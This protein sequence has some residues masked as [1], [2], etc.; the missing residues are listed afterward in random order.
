M[1]DHAVSAVLEPLSGHEGRTLVIQNLPSNSTVSDLIQIARRELGASYQSLTLSCD[2]VTLAPHEWLSDILA[3]TGHNHITY[4]LRN[5]PSL[6]I[7]L[8]E[9]ITL[10]V[11]QQEFELRDGS[12]ALS[13]KVHNLLKRIDESRKPLFGLLE[14]LESAGQSARSASSRAY[15]AALELNRSGVLA[16]VIAFSM[17]ELVRIEGIAPLWMQVLMWTYFIGCFTYFWARYV[18]GVN[19]AQTICNY[20]PTV[21][22]AAPQPQDLVKFVPQKSLAYIQETERVVSDMIL[23]ATWMQSAVMFFAS[24]MPSVYREWSTRVQARKNLHTDAVRIIQRMKSSEAETAAI[25]GVNTD[26]NGSDDDIYVEA[27][28]H[29]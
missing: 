5:V 8:G 3:D 4:V 21:Y 19:L 13:S 20:L 27:M 28:E 16:V 6:S 25:N 17:A 26:A 9:G 2:H 22:R 29:L 10:Q 18:R 12:I 11:D 1:V 7:N 15:H 14:R 24:M 23:P